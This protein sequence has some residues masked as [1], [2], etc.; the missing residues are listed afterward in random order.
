[1]WTEDMSITEEKILSKKTICLVT[2][3]MSVAGGAQ[4]VT[5]LMAKELSSYYN[6]IVVSAMTD[7]DGKIAYD[8]PENVKV[9]KATKGIKNATK[10]DIISS[11][12]LTIS[13]SVKSSA[14]ESRINSWFCV[15]SF[16]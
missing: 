11:V 15:P 8:F 10:A 16:C 5:S 2:K 3:N 6:V 1:M 4:R 7:A 14:V 9:I 13:A 12:R